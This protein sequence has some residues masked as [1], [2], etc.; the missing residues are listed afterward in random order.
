[1]MNDGE[2]HRKLPA[3]DVSV[4]RFNSYAFDLSVFSAATGKP[5]TVSRRTGRLPICSIPI[6]NDPVFKENPQSFRAELHRRFTE[7]TLSAW[8]LL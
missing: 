6:P 3:G 4:I 8:F 1:M 2:I 5:T 7:W